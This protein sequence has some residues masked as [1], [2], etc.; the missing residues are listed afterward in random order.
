MD[1][2]TPS[3]LFAALVCALVAACS[4]QKQALDTWVHADTG[5]YGAAISP[6]GKHLLTG[7]IGGFARVWDL[8]NNKVQYSVQH[9]DGDEGGI[10]GGR[11]GPADRILA[12]AQPERCRGIGGWSPCAHRQQ[13]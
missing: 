10:I 13:G 7:E 8:Q 11:L 12:M 4:E 1:R 2:M 3:I 6:D 5:S 9:E